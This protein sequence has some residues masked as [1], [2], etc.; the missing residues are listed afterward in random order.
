[1]CR[2]NCNIPLPFGTGDEGYN[3]AMQELVEPRV[4]RFKPDLIVVPLGL[5]ASAVSFSVAL[6]GLV[7]SGANLFPV[8]PVE[9]LIHWST[10]KF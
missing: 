9:F 7:N 1:M 3:V 10:S 6:P 2:Y 8:C 5:D 4:N